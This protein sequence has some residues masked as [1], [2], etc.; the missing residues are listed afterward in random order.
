MNRTNYF[1]LAIS[2]GILLLA[3][4]CSSNHITVP[5]P[6]Y[7]EI[8]VES[9]SI[10]E[11]LKKARVE[12]LPIE[13]N[14]RGEVATVLFPYMNSRV[15]ADLTQ[16]KC[17]LRDNLVAILRAKDVQ[18][19]KNVS[20]MENMTYSQKRKTT[21]V[22]R[23]VINL[24]FNHKGTNYGDF[25]A[26]TDFK[27]KSNISFFTYEP[28]TGEKTWQKTL[29]LVSSAYNL[30]YDVGCGTFDICENPNYDPTYIHKGV[31]SG[32]LEVDRLIYEIYKATAL[33]VDNS[34][35]RTLVAKRL[36][37]ALELKGVKS[38]DS[39][40]NYPAPTANPTPVIININK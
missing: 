5:L 32:V 6:H 21:M 23:V 1:K 28:I 4:A 33:G 12:V 24:D 7:D 15:K 13:I 11:E 36:K 30:N 40:A 35:T 17:K 37:E 20:S 16:L 31:V 2:L 34:F 18:A 26:K 14:V 22:L 8:T 25:V 38:G 3:S 10:T 27:T 19:N 9:F 29:P 39:G